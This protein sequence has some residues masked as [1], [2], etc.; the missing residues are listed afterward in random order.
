[1]LI[2]YFKYNEDECP[3]CEE[4]RE[5]GF[6]FPSFRDFQTNGIFSHITFPINE[7]NFPVELSNFIY[8]KNWNKFSH[9][10]FHSLY[11]IVNV[12][13]NYPK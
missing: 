10:P 4:G 13:N 8:P 5:C 7:E 1:M 6:K 9:V 11:N 3:L 2:F 12:L